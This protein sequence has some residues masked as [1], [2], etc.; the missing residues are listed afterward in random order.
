MVNE[1]RIIYKFK[2]IFFIDVLGCLSFINSYFFCRKWFM[3][4][5]IVKR[6]IIDIVLCIIIDVVYLNDGFFFCF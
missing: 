2:L 5:Y 4:M 3:Y 1:N 6:D